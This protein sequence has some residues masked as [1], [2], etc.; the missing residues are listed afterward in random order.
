MR[1]LGFGSGIPA[2]HPGRVSMTSLP[3]SAQEMLCRRRGEGG[4]YSYP[5][6]LPR[7]DRA[8]AVVPVGPVCTLS[9]KRRNGANHSYQTVEDSL[10]EEVE[11]KVES[12]KWRAYVRGK[13]R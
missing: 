5:M 13:W 10:V 9:A 3:R 7:M 8:S 4:E 2:E 12:G 11:E 1:G 6:E